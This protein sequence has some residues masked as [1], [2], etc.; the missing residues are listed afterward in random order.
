VVNTYAGRSSVVD[1]N[2]IIIPSGA[3]SDNLKN[4]ELGVK[5][6]WLNG[7]LS[8]NLALYQIDWSDIQVQA[9]RVSDSVQ[10]A[11]NIG[12]ARSKGVEFEIQTLPFEHLTIGLNGSLN[13][14]KV[15]KLSAAEAAISGA[16]NGARLASPHFQGSLLVTYNVALTQQAEGNLSI[17]VQHVGSFP[18]SFPRVPG[19]P[20]QMSSTYDFTEAYTVVGSTF[21]V[22]LG[23]LTVGAYVENLFDNRSVTYVHPEAFL[24]SR[25]STLQPRTVG[26]RL[27]YDF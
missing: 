4:Y 11:T 16:T 21:A 27:G 9:N 25:Y 5:G 7:K 12:A 18:G 19:K 24:A 1:P 14:A 3:S 15:T 2:D 17:G 22:A 20:T 13:D 8:A 26:V 23:G 6:N 10:F